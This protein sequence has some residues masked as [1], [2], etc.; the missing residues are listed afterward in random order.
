MIMMKAGVWLHS[1]AGAEVT[2]L[3]AGSQAS[4]IWCSGLSEDTVIEGLTITG[5]YRDALANDGGGGIHCRESHLTITGNIIRDNVAQN[6]WG[7]A[8]GGGIFCSDS[9]NAVI[10]NNV[11]TGNTSASYGAGIAVNSSP[12]IANNIIVG[13]SAETHGGGVYC[14]E[15]NGE[16]MS[17][18]I[19]GNSAAKGGGVYYAWS[20]GEITSNTIVENSA[21]EGAAVYCKLSSSP[22]ISQNIIA[23]S[24]GGAALFCDGSSSPTITCNDLWNNEGGDGSCTLGAD[25]FS[26]DP[27]FCNEAGDDYHIHQ[28]SPCAT[29]N[30]PGACGLVGALP[31]GC[32]GAPLSPVGIT[33][34]A[35]GAG[36]IG[37]LRLARPR[38]RRRDH[39][40]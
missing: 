33:L 16:I 6:I 9:P 24:L 26:A 30:S 29:S 25:N 8:G 1:E 32:W 3:D 17:S 2:V 4:V 22:A 21:P 11:I 38:V 35:V 7:G 27:M 34:I 37:A 28:D 12:T 18:L 23:H 14:V 19:V 36:A 31:V 10:A 15:F 40:Y 5:G 20:T 13:N 39:R